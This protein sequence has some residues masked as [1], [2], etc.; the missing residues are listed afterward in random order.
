MSISGS[1]ICNLV[2]IFSRTSKQFISS[3]KD[4]DLVIETLVES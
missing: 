4:Y 1:S 3:Y 2:I